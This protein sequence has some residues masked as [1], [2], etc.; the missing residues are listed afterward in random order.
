MRFS[1]EVS[2]RIFS[3]KNMETELLVIDQKPPIPQSWNYDESVKKMKVALYKWKNMTL[4]M[5]NE[6]WIAREQLSKEGR[7]IITGTIVP[8]KT[9]TDYCLEIGSQRQVV[10]RWINRWYLPNIK[11][12]P[13]MPQITAG[14]YNIIYADP[15]WRYFEDGMKNQS[16]HY[17]TMSLEDICHL[18]IN[19][20]AA[21]DCILFMWATFPMLDSFMDVL[22][23]WGFEYSTVGFVWV[24]S[25]KDKNG[26]AFGLGAWTRSNAE[27][28]VIAKRGTIPRQDASISQIIYEP[29]GEHS[30]KPPIVREKIVKLVGDLPRIELFARG[31]PPEGWTFWG[32]EVK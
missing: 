9:W 5:A 15:P 13:E 30:A 7:P 31:T 25:T 22:R 29:V 10:N 32:N 8:V 3:D 12:T 19:S 17:N 6:L 18:D 11:S 24:K 27:I 2:A 28:C 23:C 16:Q 26:F 21:D 4:E 14:K 20:L 1:V